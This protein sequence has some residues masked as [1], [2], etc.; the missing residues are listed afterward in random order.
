[1]RIVAL[2][3]FAMMVGCSSSPSN[4]VQ[5]GT[6]GGE[7]ATSPMSDDTTEGAGA[8]PETGSPEITCANVRCAEGTHCE[9]V[10]VQC[11][12]APCPPMPQC[13]PD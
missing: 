13:V 4:D 12:R 3:F 5:T 6:T 7:T 2:L 1:M 9:M 11:V 8:E 10:Q